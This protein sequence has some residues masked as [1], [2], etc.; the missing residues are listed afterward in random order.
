MTV[1]F[2]AGVSTYKKN[3]QLKFKREVWDKL[4]YL[5]DKGN[6]EIGGYGISDPDDPF[7]ITDFVM[8]K[9]DA[10][11]ATVDFDDE[12]LTDHLIEFADKDVEPWQCTRC[13]IHTHPGNS[14]HP[15]G[16]DEV[17]FRDMFGEMSWGIMFILAKDS[18]YTCRMICK[19]EPV[20]VV[21]DL[22][23]KVLPYETA[24]EHPE[25][26]AE[27][28]DKLTRKTYAT[29]TTSVS[30]WKQGYVW[31]QTL[32]KYVSPKGHPDYDAELDTTPWYMQDDGSEEWQEAYGDSA[33][34]TTYLPSVPTLADVKAT[35]GV[36]F[37]TIVISHSNSEAMEKL[38]KCG[39]LLPNV[40]G[41]EHDF[42]VYR[43]A[44]ISPPSS[45]VSTFAWLH[46][47]DAGQ[48]AILEDIGN[49]KLLQKIMKKLDSEEHK[50]LLE[51]CAAH[52]VKISK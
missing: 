48:P 28:D 45:S 35:Y 16:T 25:W 37:S 38:A 19:S 14:A 24:T 29:N 3:T 6:T 9:Q 2:Q 52:L 49:P 11:P 15:S 32:R 18:S 22:P 34:T 40:L 51:L 13:W 33:S 30:T 43:C 39:T 46:S 8:V 23:V 47:H 5:R 44:D 21:F 27:Y 17:T 10:G 20:E 36:E 4:I 12:G 7:L 1:G 42:K 31:D 41:Q 26:D 50:E